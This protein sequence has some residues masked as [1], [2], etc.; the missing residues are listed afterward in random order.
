MMDLPP[1]SDPKAPPLP[2]LFLIPQ[3][4]DKSN[5]Q[6]SPAQAARKKGP[7]TTGASK[8]ACIQWFQTK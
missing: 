3:R 2:P 1:S 6:H 8:H 7:N 4:W 5:P